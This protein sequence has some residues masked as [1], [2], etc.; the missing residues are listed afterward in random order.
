MATVTKSVKWTSSTGKDIEATIIT[1]REMRDEIVYADG[2]SVNLGPRP[3]TYDIIKVTLD[4][5]LIEQSSQIGL[6]TGKAKQQGAYGMIG[7]KVGIA[8]P[9]IYERILTA[10]AE[11]KA[12][13]ATDPDYAAYA[14][15]QQAKETEVDNKDAERY[16]RQVKNG[17]CP[18]CGTYC[19]GDCEAN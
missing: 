16:A 10:I 15:A 13:A 1:T 14:A 12:E 18:K 2:D 6:A 9:A 5:K 3:Y 4:G 17:L 19:Y 7:S 11:A 8:D